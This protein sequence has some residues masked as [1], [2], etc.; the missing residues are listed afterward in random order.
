MSPAHDVVITG[1]GVFSAFGFGER[2][3]LDG[4]FGGIPAF[5]PVTRFDV[6]RFACQYAATFDGQG[7]L[8]P[9]MVWEPTRPATPGEVLRA[10]V[11]QALAMSGHPHRSSL[12][13][14]AATK[15]YPP[16][17]GAEGAAAFVD[18]LGSELGLGSPRRVFVNACVAGANAIIHAAQLVRCGVTAAAVV[19]A[20]HLIDEQ[21]FAEF[22][23]VRAL[24]RDGTLRPFDR[25][26]NGLL[27]GDGAA[28][29]VLESADSA[30]GRNAEPQAQLAGWAMTDDAFHI[31]QPRADGRGVAAAVTESLR[32]A[33]VDPAQVSYVNAHGT[34]TALND[35]AEVAALQLSLGAHAPST[36]VSSTKSTTGHCLQACGGVELV[37]TLLALRH[38]L[39]PP[40]A[41]LA[42]P[43]GAVDHVA[44]VARHADLSHAVSINS[45]VGGINSAI[46]LAG[47]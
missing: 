10:C 25:K 43:E 46:L 5:Q 7:D 21:I 1:Y 3:L 2:A 8:P 20:V 30:R 47:A 38:G 6:S 19:G 33:A 31:V 29:L 27:L 34:G 42:E 14:I 26:R 11:E 36:A 39:L 45:A 18:R 28:A 32:R 41:G 22:D 4:V 17:S 35:S 40:T 37:I 24:S 9:G 44:R 12:P 15:L 13:L 23:A 16:S